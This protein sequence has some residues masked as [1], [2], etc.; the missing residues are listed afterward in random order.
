MAWSA[1]AIVRRTI[2]EVRLDEETKDDEL[3]H[4]MELPEEDDRFLFIMA[5]AFASSD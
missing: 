1:K 5:S 4:V 2:E 3:M